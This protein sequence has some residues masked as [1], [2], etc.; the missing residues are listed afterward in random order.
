VLLQRRGAAA[1]W[2][3]RNA[4]GLVKRCTQITTTLG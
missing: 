3:C 2:L 4:G 1:A